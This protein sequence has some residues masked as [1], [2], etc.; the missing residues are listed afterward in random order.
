MTPSPAR[1]V[2]GPPEEVE[3]IYGLKAKTLEAWR[4]R[5]KGPRFVKA[6]GRVLYRF[7]DVEA[8]LDANTHTPGTNH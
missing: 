8:Y 4:A 7:A 1:K 2:S 5:G 3:A 6:E